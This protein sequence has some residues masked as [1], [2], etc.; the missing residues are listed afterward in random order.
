MKK[1]KISSKI[2]P[3][4]ALVAEAKLVDNELEGPVFVGA[5]AVYLHTNVSRASQDID[6]ALAV[7]LTKEE[8]SDK[9]YNTFIEKGK[10]VIRSQRGYKL[11]I[12]NEDLNEIPVD[13]IIQSS[14]VIKNLNVASIE[15]MI[16]TK[17]RAGRQQD[18]QDIQE[19]AQKKAKTVDWNKIKEL[20]KGNETEYIMIK[21]TIKQYE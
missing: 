18:K 3:M 9:G 14:V 7:K 20:C 5:I 10:E 15:V 16:L 21:N 19:L 17:F 8:L 13:K 4:K 12:Y 6:L 2:D 11:D 1:N